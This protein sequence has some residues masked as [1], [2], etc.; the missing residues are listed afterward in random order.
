MNEAVKALF[1]RLKAD[2]RTSWVGGGC[3]TL[4]GIGAGLGLA[5]V[6]PWGTGVSALAIVIACAVLLFTMIVPK[7]P[8]PGAT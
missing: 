8:P 3:L 1:D 4:Y 5:G 6:E 2:P 7:D